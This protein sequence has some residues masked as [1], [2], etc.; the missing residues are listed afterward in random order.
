MAEISATRAEAA[1]EEGTSSDHDGVHAAEM[2]KKQVM[3]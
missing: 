3:Y 1:L 2:L